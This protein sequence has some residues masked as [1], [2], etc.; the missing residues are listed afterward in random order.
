MQVEGGRETSIN[1]WILKQ[2]GPVPDEPDDAD[3][4]QDAQPSPVSSLSSVDSE[5]D[6]PL[7]MERERDR[8]G[9][10]MDMT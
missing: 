10:K 2:A 7:K 5:P 3:A 4:Q 1:E 8:E 9:D 6:E